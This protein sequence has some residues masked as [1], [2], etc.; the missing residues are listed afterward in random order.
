LEISKSL[1][2]STRRGISKSF[3]QRSIIFGVLLLV[4]IVSSFVSK[5]FLTITNLSNVTRQV[6]MVIITGCAAT[7]L[8]ISG[9]IDLSSGSLVALTGVLCAKFA[10]MGY[11]LWTAI[12]LASICGGLVGLLNGILVTKL[13]MSSVIATLGTMYMARGLA[14]IFAD[15]K[16]INV[17]LP[18]NFVLLGRTSLGPVPVP[19]II[20]IVVVAL[21]IFIQNKTLLGRYSYAIGGN[22]VTAVLSG[23]NVNMIVL[24]LYVLTGVFAGFSGTILAARLGVGH[25]NVGVGFEFDVIIAIIIG[26]TS[27]TGGE[28]T[29]IGMVI[30]AFIVG[31]LSNVLNLMGVHT[32]YQDVVKGVVL[33]LAVIMDIVIRERI[34]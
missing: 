26:G 27:L 9:N 3:L 10:V 4:I 11:P 12:L 34:K 20:T 25:P 14:L 18:A 6:A 19:L 32:F 15:G 17:G 24:L 23:V 16:T 8:M 21:F 1:E 22:R 2:V 5:S 33:V 13:R 28:G 30:G 7:L 31:F 29:V